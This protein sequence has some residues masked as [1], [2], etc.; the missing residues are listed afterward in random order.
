MKIYKSVMLALMSG[1]ILRPYAFF[2]GLGLVLLM[3]ALYIIGWIFFNTFGVYPEIPSGVLPD[4]R[5]SEAIALVFRNR[6]HAFLVGGV[7]LIVALQFL[8]MGFLSLQNKRYFEELFHIN[9]SL[10]KKIERLD[11]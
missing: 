8:S 6:P 4:D 7:T 3:V 2:M 11:K 9:T 1:F 5:F 10:S